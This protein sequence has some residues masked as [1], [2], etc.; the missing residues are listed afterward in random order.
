[1]KNITGSKFNLVSDLK[2][3]ISGNIS[4]LDSMILHPWNFKMRQNI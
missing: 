4:E 1:M 3:Y 2:E